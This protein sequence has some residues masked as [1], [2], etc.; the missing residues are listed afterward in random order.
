MATPRVSRCL[1]SKAHTWKA[2]GQTAAPGR[3]SH[4][5]AQPLGLFFQVDFIRAMRQEVELCNQVG[6][7]ECVLGPSLR[8]DLLQ[9][10]SSTMQ[11]LGYTTYL[12]FPFWGKAGPRGCRGIWGF[13]SAGSHSSGSWTPHHQDCKVLLDVPRRAVLWELRLV[14]LWGAEQPRGCGE[15][16]R[17]SSLRVGRRGCGQSTG[18]IICE[19]GGVTAL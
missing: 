15:A 16:P 2:K 12:C 18:S 14:P 10:E 1:G 19:P 7:P 13:V 11:R 4:L 8:C 6:L 17:D 3:V 5:S 9:S